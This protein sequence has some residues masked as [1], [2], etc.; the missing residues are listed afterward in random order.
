MS[1]ENENNIENTEDPDYIA[2]KEKLKAMLEAANPTAPAAVSD[3]G[4]TAAMQGGF[5]PVAQKK[6]SLVDIAAKLPAMLDNF[7]A[8]DVGKMVS[9]P[10]VAGSALG[11]AAG[12]KASGAGINPFNTD[13]FLQAK[14][15]GTQAWLNGQLTANPHLPQKLTLQ[16]LSQ[17]TGMNVDTTDRIWAALQRLQGTPAQREPVIKNIDGKQVVTGYRQIPEVPPIDLATARQQT[18]M[19]KIGNAIEDFAPG[20]A[21]AGRFVK[22]VLPTLGALGTGANIGFSAGDALSRY[23]GDDKTGAG[24]AAVGGL[25][26]LMLNPAIGVP[27]GLAAMGLNAARDNPEVLKDINP[28][29]Y[30]QGHFKLKRPR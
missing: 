1:K 4:T 9:D 10:A 30:L 17:L 14:P 20:V 16:E 27:V 11:A 3:V 24:I 5:Q 12:Y 8:S 19:G 2:Y 25:A 6:A 7:P 21:K 15:S 22:G 26:P 29:Q 18:M 23:M 28:E 13:T